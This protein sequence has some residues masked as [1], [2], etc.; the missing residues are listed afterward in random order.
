MP[1]GWIARIIVSFGRSFTVIY[2]KCS[3]ISNLSLRI[4]CIFS[5]LQTLT[6]ECGMQSAWCQH[7]HRDVRHEMRHHARQYAARPGPY[8]RKQKPDGERRD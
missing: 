7:S 8:G 5:T 3:C 6:L 1:Y 4:N 2:Y